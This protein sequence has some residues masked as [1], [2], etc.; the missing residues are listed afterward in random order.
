VSESL[1]LVFPSDAP[2][3]DQIAAF[4][5][6]FPTV[7][8]ADE[9]HRGR[10]VYVR[11]GE[12]SAWVY[13]DDEPEVVREEL[14]EFWPDF[15]LPVL[16][17]ANFVIVEYRLVSLAKRVVLAIASDTDFFVDTDMLA[18]YTSTAFVA[19]CRIEPEWSWLRSDTEANEPLEGVGRAR[20]RRS[21]F[22]SAWPPQ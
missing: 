7:S 4:L 5:T 11:D 20:A 8:V 6:G 3:V 15:L 1:I 2:S 17:S 14:A 10:T 9:T 22:Y 12:Q 16:E 13:H 21:V 19:R 18:I